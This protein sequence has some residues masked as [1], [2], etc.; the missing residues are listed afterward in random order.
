MIDLPTFCLLEQCVLIA[1]LLIKH[2]LLSELTLVLDMTVTSA[3]PLPV[4]I[5]LMKV[6][7]AQPL[8]VLIDLEHCLHCVDRVSLLFSVPDNFVNNSQIYVESNLL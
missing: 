5:D 2:V 3:Q 6:M 7:S 1:F 8:P 4:V